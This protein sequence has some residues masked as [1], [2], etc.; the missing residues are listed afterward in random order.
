M[1]RHMFSIT[2]TCFQLHITALPGVALLHGSCSLGPILCPGFDSPENSPSPLAGL[3]GRYVRAIWGN[4]QQ[5]RNAVQ[6]NT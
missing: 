2:L 4:A 3:V 1:F 6:E 5:C